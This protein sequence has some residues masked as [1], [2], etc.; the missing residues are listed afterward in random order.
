MGGTW[1]STFTKIFALLKDRY[2]IEIS[3]NDLVNEL[4]RSCGYSKKCCTEWLKHLE[5]FGFIHHK[6]FGRY[7]VCWDLE[8]PGLFIDPHQKKLNEDANQ[9]KLF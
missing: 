3:K 6:G 2:P 9:E 7:Q 5:E 4:V 1:K 8:Q